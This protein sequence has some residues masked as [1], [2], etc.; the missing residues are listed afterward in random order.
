MDRRRYGITIKQV[1]MTGLIPEAELIEPAGYYMSIR[2]FDHAKLLEGSI[3]H[4]LE[5]NS[6]LPAEFAKLAPGSPIGAA[7]RHGASHDR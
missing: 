4:H 3:Q 5:D 6:C 7:A 1:E 2:A